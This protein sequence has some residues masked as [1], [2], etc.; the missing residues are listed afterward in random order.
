MTSKYLLSQVKDIT[1][2][3]VDPG[4][5]PEEFADAQRIYE[6]G[7]ADYIT[8]AE[9]LSVPILSAETDTTGYT[10]LRGMR[11]LVRATSEAASRIVLDGSLDVVYIDANHSE[12]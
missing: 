5:T 8:T 6:E 1:L 2:L 11:S 7:G 10:Q 3:G 9:R 12:A 4:F